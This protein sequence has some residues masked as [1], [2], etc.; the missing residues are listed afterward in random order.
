GERHSRLAR[1]QGKVWDQLYSPTSLAQ[2]DNHARGQLAEQLSKEL[3]EVIGKTNPKAELVCQSS[4][5]ALILRAIPPALGGIGC[6][7]EECVAVAREVLDL[8]QR[9]MA[10]MRDYRN[11]PFMLNKYLSW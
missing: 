2:V 7:S 8:H 5:L 4:L 3:R 11:N 9:C 10:S 6:A 1:I